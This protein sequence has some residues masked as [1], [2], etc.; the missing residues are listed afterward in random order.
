MRATAAAAAIPVEPKPLPARDKVIIFLILF[1]AAI[2]FTLEAYWLIFNQVMESRSDVFARI[3]ALYWPADYTYRIPGYPI[4]KSFTL[5]LEGVNTLVTPF[6][7]FVLIRAIVKRKPYRY[8]L[9]LAIATYTF[10]GT[11]LYY[12]VARISGHAVFAYQGAYPYLMFYLA[13]LP[14]F[15]AYGWMSWDAYRAIV[16]RY[17]S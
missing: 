17:K 15:A 9:Q 13:N 14:W 11:F 5:A 16:Q 1:F 2:A 6:L 4:A 3:L 8:P 12:L 7:S 10:Y